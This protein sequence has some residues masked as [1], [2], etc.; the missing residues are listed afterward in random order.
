MK[1]DNKLHV[2]WLDDDNNLPI[3]I[4]ADD[5]LHGIDVLNGIL[6]DT[7]Q[8]DKT[9]KILGYSAGDCSMC[10]HF[11]SHIDFTFCRVETTS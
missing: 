5:V 7:R 4:N 8:P 11:Y 3:T 9:V 10:G 1:S 6:T 2:L